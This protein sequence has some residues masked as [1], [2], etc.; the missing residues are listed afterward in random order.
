MC[1][2]I[3]KDVRS[4]SLSIMEWRVQSVYLVIVTAGGLV[5]VTFPVQS[6]LDSAHAKLTSKVGE[7]EIEH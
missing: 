3:Q 7:V 4:V 1:R 5:E 2:P 6:P